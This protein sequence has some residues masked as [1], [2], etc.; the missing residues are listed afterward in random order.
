MT[1]AVLRT[2]R[3]KQ[4]AE[5]AADGDGYRDSG[6]VFTNLNSD[7]VAPGRLTHVFQKLIAEHDVPPIRLHDLRHGTATLWVAAGV[8]LKVVQEMLGHSSIVL[9]AD[10]YTSVLPEVA[11]TAVEKTAAYLLPTAGVVLGTARRRGSAPVR[12][13]RPAA[14]RTRAGLVR[15]RSTAPRPEP[16]VAPHAARPAVRVRATTRVCGVIESIRSPPRPSTDEGTNR[17][18]ETRRLRAARRGNGLARREDWADTGVLGS[19]WEYDGPQGGPARPRH[20]RPCAA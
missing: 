15:R 18:P 20:D 7:P 13:R 9:T 16:G 8:Q 14:S 19:A 11:P 1:I 2:H 12:R 6:Y 17:I 10:T 5:A 3:S 4:H